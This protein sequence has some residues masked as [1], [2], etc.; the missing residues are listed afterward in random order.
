M[1]ITAKYAALV[2]VLIAPTSYSIAEDYFA[3]PFIIGRL[4]PAHTIEISNE[5]GEVL[6][7]NDPKWSYQDYP[8]PEKPEEVI[9][10]LTTADGKRWNAQWV[11]E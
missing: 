11:S 5:L 4:S 6:T 3:D 7:I 1:N 2:A 10:T 8:R 9:I